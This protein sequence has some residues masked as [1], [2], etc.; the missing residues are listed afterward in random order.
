MDIEI[1]NKYREKLEND[2]SFI[3]SNEALVEEMEKFYSTLFSLA[4]EYFPPLVPI[5]L[6]ANKLKSY[7]KIRKT[8]S[9]NRTEIYES[10]LQIG[11]YDVALS[12]EGNKETY[13]R[14]TYYLDYNSKVYHDFIM[15]AGLVDSTI[16]YSYIINSFFRINCSNTFV[17][18]CSGKIDISLYS[19]INCLNDLDVYLKHNDSHDFGIYNDINNK[20]KKLHYLKTLW[21]SINNKPNL[22]ET[23]RQKLESEKGK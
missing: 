2:I 7:E 23:I 22:I 13:W 9:Y 6:N 11:Y 14:T 16:K 21:E 1:K 18:L 4:K 12:I 19:V 5:F 17:E 20:I 8:S 3:E 10:L 15:S